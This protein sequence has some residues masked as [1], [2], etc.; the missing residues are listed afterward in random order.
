MALYFNPLPQVV[1]SS[2]CAYTTTLRK[3]IRHTNHATKPSGNARN[4]W[5]ASRRRVSAI[6]SDLTNR[7]TYIASDSGLSQGTRRK[8]KRCLVLGWLV[9]LSFAFGF[10]VVVSF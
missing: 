6:H 4:A 7:R 3:V 1:S 5:I 2:P 9:S 8:F 10:S